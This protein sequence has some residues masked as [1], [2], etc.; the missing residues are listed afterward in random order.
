MS[1]HRAI[2][3]VQIT[4]HDKA[5]P[6]LIRIY[7]SENSRSHRFAVKACIELMSQLLTK[8]L[9]DK[10]KIL[11]LWTGI[12]TSLQTAVLND[13]WKCGAYLKKK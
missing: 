2:E 6:V 4:L 13:L 8:P 1:Y 3:N 12:G 10:I 7:T 11:I 9:S 5:S